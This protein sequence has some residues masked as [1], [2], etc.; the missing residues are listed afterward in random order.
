MSGEARLFDVLEARNTPRCLFWS[1]AGVGLRAILVIDDCTLG[2]AA[3]GIRTRAYD[4]LAEAVDDAAELARAMTLKCSL[5]GVAAGGA[6]AV[7]L[8]HP[9]LDRGAAF[10]RLGRFVAEL[11]GHFITAGDLGTT[12]ADLERMA[13]CCEHV[14]TGEADLA[15]AVARGL[16]RCVEACAVVAGVAGVAGLRVAVQ[17]V[18]AIGGAVSRALA[19]AGA[20]LFVADIDGDRAADI[21]GELAASVLEPGDVL[22]ADVDIICPCAIGGVVTADVAASMSAWALCGGANNIVAGAEAARCLHRRGILHVPDIVSSAGAVVDGVGEM[23]MGLADRSALID[24]LGTTARELL[25]DSK[26]LDRPTGELAEERAWARIA[27]A[28]RSR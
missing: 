15:A 26:R 20:E 3:G 2:P 7:L 27:D 25:E 10:E 16:L 22:T 24:A 19:A 17:G 12:A 9:G 11:D 1:D 5:G 21:A 14:H 6:K 23:V 28:R 8:D 13:A 18:G 4:S